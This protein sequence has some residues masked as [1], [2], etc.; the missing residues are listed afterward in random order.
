MKNRALK[1]QQNI[2]SFN[3][4]YVSTST[5]P[6][7]I[8]SRGAFPKELLVNSLWWEGPDWLKLSPAEWLVKIETGDL[9]VEEQQVPTPMKRNVR[10]IRIQKPQ[11]EE[12]FS[13]N[14]LLKIERVLAVGRKWKLK[15]ISGTKASI[16]PDSQDLKSARQQLL[17]LTQ[18]FYFPAE[19]EALQKNR[20]IPAKSTI[21]HLN[22]FLDEHGLIRLQGRLR[23]SDMPTSSKQPILLTKKARVT[24]LLLMDPHMIYKHPSTRTMMAIFSNEYFVSGVRSIA[25]KIVRSCVRCRHVNAVTCQQK[26]GQLP[27]QRVKFELAFQEVGVDYAGPILVKSGSN[28]RRPTLE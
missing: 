23:N 28:K 5:N 25:R 17:H 21:G 7:D 20:A 26:M 11:S 19:T 13:F 27:S 8:V 24:Y 1:I 3:W 12:L 14:S 22:P 10:I 18:E 9:P 4:R 16:R 6:A 2:S 15:A